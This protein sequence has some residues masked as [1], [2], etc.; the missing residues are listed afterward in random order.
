MSPAVAP[1][2]VQ[3]DVPADAS[4]A[5]LVRAALAALAAQ[6]DYTLDRI[7]DLRLAGTEAFS[8]AV[9]RAVAGATVQVL[10]TAASDGITVRTIAPSSQAA[11]SLG[12]PGAIGWT[13]LTALVDEL[14][15][16]SEG[17]TAQIRL[18]VSAHPGAA[19]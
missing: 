19:S 13:L 6:A 14:A 10:I 11:L 4:Y 1:A 3:L 8:L 17:T 5:V 7:E 16:E 18:R 12:G 15:D 2:T 9:L